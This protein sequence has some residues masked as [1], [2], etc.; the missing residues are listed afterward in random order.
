M[1]DKNLVIDDKSNIVVDGETF[2]GTPGLWQL[3]M[4]NDPVS[5]TVDDTKYK[6][7]LFKKQKRSS[8]KVRIS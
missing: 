1:G 2:T 6:Y 8:C 3:V 7:L 4:L 5:Y